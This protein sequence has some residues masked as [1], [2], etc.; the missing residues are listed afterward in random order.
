ME[1]FGW[2]RM[3]KL[4]SLTPPASLFVATFLATNLLVLCILVYTLLWKSNESEVGRITSQ[5]IIVLIRLLTMHL[6]YTELFAV[7]ENLKEL[8]KI[9][10]NSDRFSVVDM[11]IPTL[12]PLFYGLVNF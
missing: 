4:Q 12:Y 7:H 11:K 6:K 2:E 10:L 8:E 5:A 9:P 3:L 1:A